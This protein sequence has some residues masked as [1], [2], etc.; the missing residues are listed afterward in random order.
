M[1]DSP[2][3]GLPP[4]LERVADRI[5]RLYGHE[6]Q[7]EAGTDSPNNSA[8]ILVYIDGEF[9]GTFEPWWDSNWPAE[10]I[11]TELVGKIEEDCAQELGGGLWG[12]GFPPG[13]AEEGQTPVDLSVAESTA[14]RQALSR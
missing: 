4:G 14:T 9:V 12:S 6:V 2:P 3:P 5:R 13:W 1:A 8:E 11:L 7:L 10:E